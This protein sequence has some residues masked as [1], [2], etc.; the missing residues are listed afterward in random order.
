MLEQSPK[1]F[2]EH[3]GK[4]VKRNTRICPHCGSFFTSVR[5]PACGYTGS[6]RDFVKGCPKCGYAV[7]SQFGQ[8][9]NKDKKEITSPKRKKYSHKEALPIWVYIF[10][11]TWL[12][13]LIVLLFV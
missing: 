7:K 5:C 9:I 10:V 2:C 6:A 4:Q 1:F 13:T 3:C 8:N 11:L 12:I